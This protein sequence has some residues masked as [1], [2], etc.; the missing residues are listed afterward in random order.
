MGDSYTCHQVELV[1]GSCRKV[2]WIPTVFAVKGENV[3]ISDSSGT[4]DWTV[5]FVY[6]GPVS[7]SEANERSQDY[8]RTRRESDV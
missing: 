2:V 8:K 7:Y 1:R 4:E 6:G 3:S 5:D